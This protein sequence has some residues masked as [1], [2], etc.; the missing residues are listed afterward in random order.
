MIAVCKNCHQFRELA[1]SN[2]FDNTCIV[3]AYG[4]LKRNEE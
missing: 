2:M 1:P 3:C 4:D